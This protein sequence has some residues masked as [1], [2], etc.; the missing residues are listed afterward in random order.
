[1]REGGIAAIAD[2]VIANWLTEDFREREPQVTANLKAMLLATPVEGYIACCEMLSTLDQRELLPK[3]DKPDAGDRRPA[4]QCRRRSR[5]PNS[6]AAGFPA[7][8]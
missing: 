4:R 3:I 8:A 5:P 6:S 2:T 7:P 1:M